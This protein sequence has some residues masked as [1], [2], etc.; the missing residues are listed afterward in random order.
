MARKLDR[1]EAWL[2]ERLAAGP[3]RIQ[4]LHQMGP[5]TL[6][7]SWGTLQLAGR[8]IGVVPVQQPG[9]SGGVWWWKLPG[10][11]LPATPPPAPTV[12]AELPRDASGMAC[13]HCGDHR[14]RV[15]DTRMR[16][17]GERRRRYA[18]FT[19]KGRFTTLERI[20]HDP[21]ANRQRSVPATRA[22]SV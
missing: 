2:R 20:E 7:C 10:Q 19:C 21:A 15:L 12:A 4:V 9:V 18:C 13:P 17:S 11:Q 16:A 6:G 1:A 5:V 8:N 3:E 14:A 22:D